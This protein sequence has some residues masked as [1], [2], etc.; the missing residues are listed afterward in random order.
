MAAVPETWLPGRRCALVSPCIHASDTH[1]DLPPTVP[2]DGRVL[3]VIAAQLLC[4]VRLGLVYARTGQ[5]AV[6]RS[7]YLAIIVVRLI[8]L[9]DVLPG[10][11]VDAGQQFEK[12]HIRAWVLVC[13]AGARVLSACYVV[14]RRLSRV[15][16]GGHILST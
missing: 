5:P 14:R 1:A 2:K 7:T 13:T 16:Y 11:R 8:E 12:R 15:T 3:A 6:K 10:G 4:I 9:L